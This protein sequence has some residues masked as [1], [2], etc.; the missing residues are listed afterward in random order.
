ML[1]LRV[2]LLASDRAG[3]GCGAGPVHNAPLLPGRDDGEHLSQFRLLALNGCPNRIAL[4]GDD[5]VRIACRIKQSPLPVR[6]FGF[7]DDVAQGNAGH[8]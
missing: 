1:T 4:A 2:R 3:S 7:R 5:I 8:G 6:M